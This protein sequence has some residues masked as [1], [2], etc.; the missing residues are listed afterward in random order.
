MT[1]Q[2]D[3]WP[4]TTILMGDLPGK[5]DYTTNIQQSFDIYKKIYTPG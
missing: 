3:F 4:I 1:P 5:E 2:P